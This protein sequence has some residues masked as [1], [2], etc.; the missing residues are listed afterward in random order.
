[1]NANLDIV[2]DEWWARCRAKYRAAATASEFLTWL[3]RTGF[4]SPLLQQGQQVV[5]NELDHA[6][7]CF[8]V[9]EQLGG[10]DDPADGDEAELVLAAGFGRPTFERVVLA[11]LQRFCVQETVGLALWGALLSDASEAAPRQVLERIVADT[12]RHRAFAWA[13]LDEAIERDREATAALAERQLPGYLGMAERAW[14][15][16]PD[17][18]I[19]PVG[20]YELR[21]GLAPR[22][23]Y[24]RAFYQAVAEE[25][26]PRLDRRNLQGRAAW[27]KRPRRR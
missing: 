19:E 2:R 22:A 26:L 15:V 14:G 4:S 1:M 25:L 3:I 11:V 13:T 8:E 27:G 23:R 10:Q 21:W 9:Y 24:K 17:D 16:V 5:A 12:E 18:W 7:M 6:D 20:P